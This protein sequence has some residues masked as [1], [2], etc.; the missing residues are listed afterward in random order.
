MDQAHLNYLCNRWS[1]KKD[2]CS[3]NWSGKEITV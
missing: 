3:M 1:V 2:I